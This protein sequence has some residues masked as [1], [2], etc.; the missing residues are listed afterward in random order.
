[1]DGGGSGSVDTAK[2]AATYIK[3]EYSHAVDEYEFP[4]LVYG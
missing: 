3:A 2:E 4:L 1:M